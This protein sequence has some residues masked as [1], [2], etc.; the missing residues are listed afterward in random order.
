MNYLIAYLAIS[1][2]WMSG[3]TARD[4][5]RDDFNIALIT[6]DTL[7]ADH[8]SCYGYERE[9]S[10]HIDAVAKEGI[11]FKNVVSPASWTA[12]SMV[13]LFTSTYYVNHGVIHGLPFQ[14]AKGL[15]Q[16]AFSEKLVTLPELL[17][18][19]GYTTFGIS[20]N[21]TLTAEL[22]F[23]RG[24]DY[25]RD[26][27]W[28][29]ADVINNL[30]YKW[31]DAIKKSNKFFLWVHYIDPHY[32]YR[33]H[34]PWIE[35]YIPGIPEQFE[36][37]N[38][39]PLHMLEKNIKE[40]P[41][42]LTKVLALYDSEIN[43]VDS[44]VGE[45]IERFE[46]DKNSLLIIASDHGEQ[47]MEHGGVGHSIAL[48]KEEL[49]VP[50]IIKFPEAS[51]KKGSVERQVSLLD[52]M[53]TIL[54]LLG[55]YQ[56]EQAAGK[57]LLENIGIWIYLKKLLPGGQSSAHHF[58][59]LESCA[60]LK[61]IMAPP[62]NYIYGY[63]TQSGALYNTVSDP[64]EQTNLIEKHP[65]QA[66]SLKKQLFAWVSQAKKYPPRSH[67]TE[68]SPGER[69]KLQALGYLSGPKK[70]DGDNDGIVDEE[71]NCADQPNGPAKGT[72]TRG[73]SGEFC[74]NNDQCGSDGF[75]SMQQ[76][77]R[78]HDG[79]GDVCDFCEGNGAYD[80]D[81]DGV[82]DKSP[83]IIEK[84]WFEAEHAD[85]IVSPLESADDGDASEGGFIYAPNGAGNAYEPGGTIHATYTVTITRPG[86]YNFVGQGPGA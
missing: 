21:H 64:F 73:H 83:S 40:N 17:K 8:L 34:L 30:V 76:E 77:D 3:C 23:A 51:S 25:F 81:K 48:H 22:G 85:T 54:N 29:P 79:F 26:V 1:L 39:I 75:C 62:W 18:D 56:P 41:E 2:L 59:E 16:E 42:I 70:E 69:E 44:Y 38:R 13:S 68:L 14:E 57:P 9:T 84:V 19:N 43:Y 67:V 80:T 12:P 4:A 86:V 5:A 37:V 58:A 60:I 82:C 28:M 24:F 78:D 32:H 49:H 15:S 33:P 72:C 6:I 7:R 10:P 53:P 66:D 74:N 63:Q 20:S 27:N 35:R 47:F 50:L 71:D 55:I 31:E 45:L 46:L 52:V 61:T 36:Q 11:I 65:E